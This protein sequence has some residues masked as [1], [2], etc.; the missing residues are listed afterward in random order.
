MYFMSINQGSGLHAREIKFNNG[1]QTDASRPKTT[2]KQLCMVLGLVASGLSPTA[3]WLALGEEL[4]AC[5]CTHKVKAC[6]LKG[7]FHSHQ[8]CKANST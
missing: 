4:L 8:P 5:F 7:S 1:W 6:L 2:R 3:A